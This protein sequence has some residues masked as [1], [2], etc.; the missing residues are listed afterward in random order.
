MNTYLLG[1]TTLIYLAVGFN[2][3]A[4]GNLG[5]G[6]AFLAYAVANVGIMYAGGD[7]K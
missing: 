2:H 4:K 1:A 6:V 3:F 7:I 5:L